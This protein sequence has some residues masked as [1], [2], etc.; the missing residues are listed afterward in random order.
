MCVCVSGASLSC[1]VGVAGGGLNQGARSMLG[2]AMDD[3]PLYDCVASDE[4]YCSVDT[5][6]VRSLQADVKG[7]S[8]IEVV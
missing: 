7:D 1:C 8:V 3:E 5:H 2:G 6:S 4:D